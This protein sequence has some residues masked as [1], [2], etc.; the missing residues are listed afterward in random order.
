MA[1]LSSSTIWEDTYKNKVGGE[2]GDEIPLNGKTAS[3]ISTLTTKSYK[4][5]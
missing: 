2:L 3:N 5:W 1:R 4:N